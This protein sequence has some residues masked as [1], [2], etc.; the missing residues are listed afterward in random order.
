MNQKLALAT[1]AVLSVAGCRCGPGG[2]GGLLPDFSAQPLALELQ[3]CPTKDDTGATVPDVYPDEKKLTVTNNAKVSG[4]LSLTFRGADAAAFSIAPTFTTT[5]VAALESLEVPVRFSPARKGDHRAELVIDDGEETTDPVVATLV[6]IGSNL[7]ALPKIAA[8]VQNK[9]AMTTFDACQDGL[10]CQ[11][12][13]PDTLYKEAATLEV[14]LRNAG[15]PALKITGLEIVPLGAGSTNLA[16]FIDEPAVPPSAS[17]PLLL[18]QAV[19]NGETTVKVRFA[20]ETDGTG[21]TQRFALLRVKTNDPVTPEYDIQLF[22]SALE[23]AIYSIP[24]FCDFSNPLDTCGYAT[25]Q[26]NQARFTVKNGG[27]ATIKIDST[28][29]GSNGTAT[30]G[31]NGRFNIAAGIAGQTIAPGGQLT[32]DVTHTDQPLY[33][34]DTL[35]VS[36]ST[37]PGGAVGSAGRAVLTLAGGRKPCLETEPL[38]QLDFQN[39][40]AELTQK[41]VIVRN[42][43]DTNCGDLIIKNVSIDQSAFFSLVPTLIPPNE[44]VPAGQ[45]RTAKVQYK[46]PVSGGTQ[47]GVLRIETNDP[48]FSGPSWKV[49]RLYSQSPL[50]QLPV[51]IAEGCVDSGCTTV[52]SNSMSVNLSQLNPK[53]VIITGKNSYDPGNPTQPGITKWQFRLVTRP[54]NATA[55]LLANDGVEITTNQTTL[56]LDPGALG[57]YRV[58]LMVTDTANQ[59]SAI[60]S[61]LKINVNQ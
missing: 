27:S 25:R 28:N 24:T 10:L 56:T 38:D 51:P 54:S 7:A 58:T 9:D 4:P 41:D 42:K 21:D 6:G 30:G 48:D 39:P 44:V 43:N 59:R 40:T 53:Q 14:K 15:C 12:T 17:T 37:T 33:V 18:T 13:Y 23:P 61:E 47:A 19:A 32:L 31:S 29:F 26:A 36:A 3:A 8:S 46:K 35:V 16:F 52:K 2:S 49:V 34:I 50:D 60:A 5:Q 55:A 20:P 22:G 1:F 45:S 11:Q 57:L